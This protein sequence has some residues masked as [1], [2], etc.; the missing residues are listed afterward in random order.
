MSGIQSVDARRS[1]RK[2][3]TVALLLCV[4]VAA[5]SASTPAQETLSQDQAF[6]VLRDVGQTEATGISSQGHGY[7][8][9]SDVLSN[10]GWMDR[11]YVTRDL[12]I[13]IRRTGATSAAVLDYTL[14]VTVSADRQHYQASLTPPFRN[15]CNASAWFVDERLV[16]YVGHPTC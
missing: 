8:D 16:V 12:S 11:Y 2:G 5:S 4:V 1:L 14:R 3:G 15:G 10:P 6:R 7:G 13:P 9:L